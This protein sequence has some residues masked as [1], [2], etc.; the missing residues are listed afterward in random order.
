[1]T[2]SPSVN[3]LPEGQE[4][5]VRALARAMFRNATAAAVVV[6]AAA[7]VVAAVLVGPAGVL[8][9]AAGAAL[10]YASSLLTLLLMRRTATLAPQ[11]VM[12]ASFG[13][14]LLKMILILAVLFPL[15]AV[16]GVH[17]GS[18]AIGMIV[19]LIAVT[20]AEGLAGYRLRT[21]NVEPVPGPSTPAASG[22]V[23]G[24]SGS[25]TSAPTGVD[26]RTTE[27]RVR[28]NREA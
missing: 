27:G 26:G 11:A 4:Q 12:I 2:R 7:V 28:P 14:S 9:A 5:T 13:G 15:G 1:M 6:G 20:A 25:T 23:T 3:R 22:S 16:E 21:L 17:R 24:T 8:S 10:A 19:V 18:L